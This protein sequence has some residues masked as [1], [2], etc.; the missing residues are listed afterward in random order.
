MAD[1]SRAHAQPVPEVLA[2][3]VQLNVDFQVLVCLDG[4]CRC[5]VSPRAIVRHLYL[6]HKTPIELRKLVER[7][8]QSFPGSYDHLSVQLP[9]DGSFPQ[10]VIQV[11]DGFRC[12]QCPFMT[13]DYSNIRKHANKEH[14][15]K[16]VRD[17]EIFSM[18]RI[19]SWFRNGKERYWVVDEE[20]RPVPAPPARPDIVRDVGEESPDSSDTTD[21]EAEE[22]VSYDRLEG[23]IRQWQ[24]EKQERRLTLLARPAAVE[25]DPWLQYTK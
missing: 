5:A 20:A 4:E 8:I 3:L 7:Y 14:G 10:P 11:D 23:E 17:E 16:R 9:P 22:D 12:K 19:Q 15:K 2:H 1:E 21:E 13:Q 18:V 25:V 6:Q 24:D